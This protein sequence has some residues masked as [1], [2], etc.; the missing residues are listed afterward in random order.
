MIRRFLAPLALGAI[1]AAGC[2]KKPPT[3]IVHD[4]YKEAIVYGRVTTET[5]APVP[6][7]GVAVVP[8]TQD[9]SCTGES[10]GGGGAFISKNGSYRMVIGVPGFVPSRRCVS[11][12]VQ[13]A[14]TSS[15]RR[16]TIPGGP[17]TLRYADTG[18]PLDSMRIDVVLRRKVQP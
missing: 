8:V 7:S 2:S 12:L 6:D 14:L 16:D 18:A 4:P 11:M 5:G 1:A 9:E 13:T 3:E 10:V 15:W 17:L